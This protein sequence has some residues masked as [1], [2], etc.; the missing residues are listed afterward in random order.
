MIHSREDINDFARRVVIKAGTSVV[1]T[2]DGYICISN[3][4]NLVER[5]ARW[6]GVRV[7]GCCLLSIAP[8]QRSN[9]GVD[10]AIAVSP[11]STSTSNFYTIQ[12]VSGGKASDSRQ[13]WRGGCGQAAAWS[14][15]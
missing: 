3:V 11:A 9:V 12:A 5:A 1:S 6:V 10:C 2:A 4:A 7:G 15:G 13:L 14:T 8:T